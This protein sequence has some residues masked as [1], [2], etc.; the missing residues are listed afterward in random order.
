MRKFRIL[1]F[2]VIGLGALLG[3]LMWKY[4]ELVDDIIPWIALGVAWHITWEF[5]LDTKLFRRATIAL[6]KKVGRVWI[7]VIV[8][9]I[10]GVISALYW[11]GI[12]HA[13]SRLA[14]LAAQ[15]HVQPPTPPPAGPI[16]HQTPQDQVAHEDLS[17]PVLIFKDS[18]LFTTKTQTHIRREIVH[19]HK[20]LDSLHVEMSDEPASVAVDDKPKNSWRTQA[21]TNGEFYDNLVAIPKDS[22]NDP[23]TITERYAYYIFWRLAQK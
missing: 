23:K 1:V 18:P 4:P 7:W 15:H 3:W 19:F 6:G 13:L 2:E 20:F 5:I 21:S 16:E 8:F 10:G 14:S 11:A 12:Q 22:L 17:K 9:L